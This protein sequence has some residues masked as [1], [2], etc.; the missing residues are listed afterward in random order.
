[1]NPIFIAAMNALPEE[2][3][4]CRKEECNRLECE[5]F[6]KALKEYCDCMR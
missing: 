1:M 3:W 4:A 5:P 2:C 6:K